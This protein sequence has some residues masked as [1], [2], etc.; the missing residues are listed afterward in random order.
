MTLKD[1]IFIL[2]SKGLDVNF[3]GRG[4]VKRQNISPGKLIKN[5]KSITIKLG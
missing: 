3:S 4:R 2:E 5:Y 1:A